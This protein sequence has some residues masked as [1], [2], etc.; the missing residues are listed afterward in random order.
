MKIVRAEIPER[1]WL[2]LKAELKA[3]GTVA[4]VEYT[5]LGCHDLLATAGRLQ[6]QLRGKK[7]SEFVWPGDEHWD[8][9]AREAVLRLQ[10][11]FEVPLKGEELCHCRKIPALK[12]DQAVVLGAHTP[13]KVKAWTSAGSGCG[14]CRPDVE[15]VIANRI[16]KS[17]KS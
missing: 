3:D 1:E 8:I 15:R 12:I 17:V 2:E 13:E 7:L 11:R 9:L 5:A 6:A 4:H 14:T 16:S 10:D